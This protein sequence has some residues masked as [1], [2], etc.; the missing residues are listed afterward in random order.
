MSNTY[1]RAYDKCSGEAPEVLSCR[2]KGGDCR[3][4]PF[5]AETTVHGITSQYHMRKNAEE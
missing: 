1:A 4:K 3:K 5:Q 2:H